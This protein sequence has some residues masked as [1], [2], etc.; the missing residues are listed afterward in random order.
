MKIACY[1]ARADGAHP[2]A[3]FALYSQVWPIMYRQVRSLGYKLIVLTAKGENVTFPHDEKVCFDVDPKTCILSREIAWSQYLADQA[4]EQEFAM[5]EPD[6]FL[7]RVIPPLQPDKNLMLLRRDR[8]PV[9]MCFRLCRGSAWPYYNHIR[10]LVRALPAEMHV[11]GGDA[12][13]QQHYL[14]GNELHEI[15]FAGR[16]NVAIEWRDS[17]DYSE[18][19]NRAS[20]DA[21]AW[22]CNGSVG[23]QK[24]TRL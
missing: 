8:P 20:K 16:G 22:T 18:K 17:C 9:P 11:W 19:P 14:G 15:V 24:M 3:V 12:H 10:N 13:A 5:I 4:P 7:R 2:S 23:K 6:T 1:W 21:V